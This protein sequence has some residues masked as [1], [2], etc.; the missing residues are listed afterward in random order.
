MKSPKKT[1]RWRWLWL[2]AP[3]SFVHADDGAVGAEVRFFAIPPQSLETA[4]IS[5]AEQARLQII[6]RTD[7]LKGRR[8]PG[9]NGTYTVDAA[10]MVLLAK[11]GFSLQFVGPRTA[12][13]D[14]EPAAGEP[15]A[16]DPAAGNE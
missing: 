10:T 12:V 3:L 14:V 2:L 16:G 13:V 4:L 15:V 7:L 9:I 6:F 8:S 5:Y 11:S 1:P